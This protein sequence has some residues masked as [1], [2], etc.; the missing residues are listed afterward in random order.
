MLTCLP[1]EGLVHAFVVLFVV[2]DPVGLAPIYA[3]LA[4][5]LPEDER[6]RTALRAV[7]LSAGLLLAFAFTGR[8]ILGALGI[9]LPA[10][11]IAGGLLLFLLA[12]DMVFVRHSGLRTTT[13]AERE[14]ARRREDISVFPLAFPLIA[15][16]GAL[17]TVLLLASGEEGA[18]GWL[19]LTLVILAVIAVTAAA[20]CLATRITR[21]LGET[22][23]NVVTRVLGLVVAALA[24]QYVLDG[25]RAAL[26]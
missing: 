12:V 20:L 18:P 22:G 2:V 26:A 4:A 6:Q 8:Q 1:M 24:V 25:V 5:G 11:R 21:L 9:S 13:P 23:A 7:A 16:P 15:G 17:T 3:G 19:G 14:E 10:F